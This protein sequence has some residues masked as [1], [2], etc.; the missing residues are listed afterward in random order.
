MSS[1]INKLTTLVILPLSFSTFAA[2]T[3]DNAAAAS[4]T[5]N[6]NTEKS[7]KEIQDMSYF[8]PFI[9][10]LERATPIKG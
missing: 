5:T 6:P 8:W 10:K 9:R 3:A 4:N 1:L 7:Q 2:T